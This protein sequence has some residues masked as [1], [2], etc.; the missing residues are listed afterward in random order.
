[1]RRCTHKERG[2]DQAYLSCLNL[3]RLQTL[4]LACCFNQF[5]YHIFVQLLGSWITS[6]PSYLSIHPFIILL[7]D[8]SFPHLSQSRSDDKSPNN[9]S[10][11]FLPFSLLQIISIQYII[12]QKVIIVTSSYFCLIWEQ[13][14][15]K[16]K[17]SLVGLK[18]L[19]FILTIRSSIYNDSLD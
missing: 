16:K 1:M 11:I 15:N 17:C 18:I 9:L 8:F 13:S 7:P 14:R 4:N 2:K 12:L 10:Y 6:R 3:Y 5:A 19:A